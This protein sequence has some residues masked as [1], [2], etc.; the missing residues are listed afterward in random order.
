M[1]NILIK[2][3][4]NVKTLGFKTYFHFMAVK[5]ITKA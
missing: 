5:H 3:I 1:Y 4:A 2:F